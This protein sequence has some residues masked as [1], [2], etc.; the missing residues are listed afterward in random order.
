MYR[1]GYESK[2][3][4]RLEKL[5]IKFEYE[6]HVIPY[7]LSA[8]TGLCWTCGSHDIGI[9]R[10]YNPDFYFPDV[11]LFVE[12]K[13]KFDQ[14]DRRKMKS[15]CEQSEEDIRMVFMRDNYI[16]KKKSMKYSRWCDL[17][18]I[19]WAIGDIPLDWLKQ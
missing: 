3:A 10:N 7:Y 5:G 12:T 14:A 11:N 9:A 18:N 4:A 2:Q 16:S 15:I 19:Q 13:G 8:R 17:N 1:S 6:S